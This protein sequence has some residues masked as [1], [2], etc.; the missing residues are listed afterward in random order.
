MGMA[1]PKKFSRTSRKRKLG[2]RKRMKTKNGRK[3]VNRKRAAG[4]TLNVADK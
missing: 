3:M 4:R 2:F 1:Y